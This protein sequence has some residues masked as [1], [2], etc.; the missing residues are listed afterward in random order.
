MSQKKGRAAKPGQDEVNSI[1]LSRADLVLTMARL[2]N[3]PKEELLPALK[4][5]E[6]TPGP[7]DILNQIRKDLGLQ[8]EEKVLIRGPEGVEEAWMKVLP[9]QEEMSLQQILDP[10]DSFYDGLQ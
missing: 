1:Q 10:L 5:V 3:V 2:L 4:L 8:V 7:P 9:D 6:Q